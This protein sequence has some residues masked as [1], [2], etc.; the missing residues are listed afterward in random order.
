MDLLEDTHLNNNQDL[1]TW[2][3][4]KSG[5]YT[6]KSMYRWLSHRGVG[7]KRLRRVWKSRIPMKLKVFLWQISHDKLQTGVALKKENGRGVRTAALVGP[8]K[9]QNIYFLNAT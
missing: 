8:W 1:V 4:E 3:M 2:G 6:T 5:V 7:N 9:Q